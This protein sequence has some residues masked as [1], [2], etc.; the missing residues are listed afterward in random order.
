MTTFRMSSER[1]G[2]DPSAEKGMHLLNHLL[3]GGHSIQRF[4]KLYGSTK[5]QERSRWAW[6][7]AW[8][9][10][11]PHQCPLFEICTYFFRDLARG[12]QASE[13]II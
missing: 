1:G 5:A 13:N 10:P 3:R 4:V 6:G 8:A 11:G 9:T 7:A 2:L 12:P